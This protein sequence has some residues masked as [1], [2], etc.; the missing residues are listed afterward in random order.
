MF[1]APD[2]KAQILLAQIILGVSI[3]NQAKKIRA[4]VAPPSLPQIF[5][6]IWGKKIWSKQRVAPRCLTFLNAATV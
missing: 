4:S 6:A 2:K 1:F 5:W 3:Q